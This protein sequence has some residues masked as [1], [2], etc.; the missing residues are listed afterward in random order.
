MADDV[1]RLR[2]RQPIT[3]HNLVVEISYAQMVEEKNREKAWI[4]VRNC[5]QVKIFSGEEKFNGLLV[6]RQNRSRQETKT[7]AGMITEHVKKTNLW[8]PKKTPITYWWIGILSNLK[9]HRTS[10]PVTNTSKT[11]VGIS[12]CQTPTSSNLIIPPTVTN[13]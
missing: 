1:A 11:P 9:L 4:K 3:G 8:N 13:S 5:R 6:A 2:A 12:K 10:L 7:F